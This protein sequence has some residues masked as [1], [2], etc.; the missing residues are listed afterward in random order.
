MDYKNQVKLLEVAA[1]LKE[2][3]GKKSASDAG[4][5]SKDVQN[6]HRSRRK[7]VNLMLIAESGGISRRED[8]E[9]H[10]TRASAHRPAL[11][12]KPK[13]LGPPLAGERLGMNLDRERLSRIREEYEA[14]EGGSI[15]ALH[16][17]ISKADLRRYTRSE[18][19]LPPNATQ[20]Y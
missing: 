10:E 14:R 18:T 7:S 17:A 8:A 4:K 19:P 3:I 16:S 13:D 5:S 20:H 6:S 15:S 11:L 2:G 1:K 9:S 12:L